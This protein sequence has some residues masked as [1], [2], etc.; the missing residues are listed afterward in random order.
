MMNEEMIREKAK[1]R[2]TS[3]LLED[4][5]NAS[6]NL[7]LDKFCENNIDTLCLY[8][9]VCKVVKAEIIRRAGE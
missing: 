6:A 3:E 9:L 1:N 5:A 2:T 4:Y 7:S 8:E